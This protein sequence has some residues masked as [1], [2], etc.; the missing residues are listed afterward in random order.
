MQIASVRAMRPGDLLWWVPSG[1][2]S[3]VMALK[4]HWFAALVILVVASAM[5]LLSWDIRRAG[6]MGAWALGLIAAMKALDEFFDER[7][8]RLAKRRRYRLHERYRR[9]E[10]RQKAR[11]S[12]P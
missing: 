9:R 11:N 7:S 12:R 5:S 4:E 8:R 10:L 6:G 1:A 2:G 3:A